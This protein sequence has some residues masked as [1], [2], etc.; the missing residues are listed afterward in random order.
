MTFSDYIE[1]ITKSVCETGFDMFL[2]S[3]CTADGG[4]ISMKVLNG[5][6]SEDGDEAGRASFHGGAGR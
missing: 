2:P 4:E 5:E 3:L 1:V 6:L